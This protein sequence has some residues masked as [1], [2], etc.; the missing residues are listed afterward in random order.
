MM[1]NI[2]LGGLNW[3]GKMAHDAGVIMY[4]DSTFKAHVILAYNANG[5]N[6][7]KDLYA[8]NFYKN[9]QSL[10]LHKDWSKLKASFY[11]VNRGIEK[12]SDTTAA[13]NLTVGPH[14]T[15]KLSKAITLKGMY[16][17]QM[18]LDTAGNNI[19]ANFISVQA[20]IKASEKL[21]FTIGMD[22]GSGTD[23]DKYND[24]N[25]KEVNTFDRMYGLIHGHFG[26][27]DYFYRS[28]NVPGTIDYY[29]KLKLKASKKW[30]FE[31]HIHGFW[32]S[33]EVLDPEDATKTIDPFLGVENDIKLTYKAAKDVK[34]TF[35]HSIFF[36]TESLDK[37][38][39]GGVESKDNQYT[40]F[41]VTIN[42]T[43]F[44][45]EN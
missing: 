16:F 35:G 40:Y 24:P 30:K 5:W 10:W 2:C 8:Y 1:I 3:G 45:S 18:G 14:L 37:T 34:V 22:R 20:S 13:Y 26:Y 15:Y 42:P 29:L 25:Q 31:D 41:V 33:A 4:E 7:N 9:M 27:L 21:S 44:K 36:G 38:V 28:F 12:P 23:A 17:H 39:F 11:L 19:N 43:L 6:Y 32:N